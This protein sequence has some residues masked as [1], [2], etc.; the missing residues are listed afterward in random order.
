[1]ISRLE[2]FMDQFSVSTQYFQI[3]EE[4][5]EIW[6]N[7]MIKWMRDFIISKIENIMDQYSAIPK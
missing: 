2:N 6:F 5:Y 7:E 3:R 4:E 1:M